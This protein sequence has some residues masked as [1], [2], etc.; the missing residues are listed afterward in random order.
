MSSDFIQSCAESLKF[1][2][3]EKERYLIVGNCVTK[4]GFGVG[5]ESEKQEKEKA[6]EG[7]R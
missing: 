4:A 3:S 5:K 1:K 7:N 2:I 6:K